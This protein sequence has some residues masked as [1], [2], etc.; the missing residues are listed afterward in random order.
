MATIKIKNGSGAPAA[1]DLVQGEPA[2][3][4]TNKRLYTEDSGGN[5]I[6]IGTNPGVDVTFADNRKAVFGT[7]SD[8]Q[9]FHDGSNSYVQDAGDG[10]LI[11]NT[12][13]GG[14]V[15][16][17]SAGETMATF[18]SN[19]AVNL[20]YD[21]AAKLATASTGIDVT[22]TVTADGLTVNSGS[23]NTVATFQSTDRTVVIPLIDSDGSTQIRSIDGE[24]AIRTGGDG[25]SSANTVERMRIDS[26]GNVGIGTSLPAFGAISTGI[27]VEGTTAGIRLQGATTGALELYHNNGLSTIDSRTATGGSKLAFNTENTERMR[28]DSSGNVLVGKTSSNYT[29]AG[30]ELR[31]H[32]TVGGTT[33][34]QTPFFANRTTDDGAL[35]EFYRGTGTV[36]SIQTFGGNLQISPAT[37]FGVDAPTDIFL[38]SAGVTTFKTNGTENARIDASGNLLVGTTET[39]IGF[40]ASGDGCMLAPEG[41]LQ[42]ARDSANELLYL[43]KLGGNDGDII[44]LSTD[45]N[46]IGVLGVRANYI[47]IG[48]GDTQLLFN[49][50]SDAI[51]PEGLTANRDAAIDLG[52]TVS[53][54]KDL[55]LSGG[56]RGT[57]TIDITIPETSG[58]AINLEFG[59]N[60][61]TTRRTVQAYK[62]NFEPATADTGV[63]SLGQ[64]GNQWKNL[65]LS[66]GVV[67]GATS[68]NVSSKTLDDYEEGTFTGAVADASSGGNESSSTLNGTYVK[69]GAVVYV[70]FNVSNINTTGMTAGNDV[71]ITG[72]PFA[73]KSVSGTAK[74]TGTANLSVVTFEQTPFMQVNEG[75]TYVKILEVRSGAG[76]D[77]VVVSQ[78]SS[79][80]SDIHGNLVYETA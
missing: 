21:N 6:E 74:Y 78:L 8:L 77:A 80:A 48:N 69:V 56:V 75:Q 11:L 61:N 20:Y 59:N 4:L 66:G 7:G 71:F 23:T 10:A 30:A 24:F 70:Q 73:S 22:G 1:S 43:N 5:V 62:D 47:K 35:F 3:D 53:R 32:G 27:E 51:T 36:G 72:L 19:G 67:F 2:L 9:L 34:T 18:N 14:W 50:G 49:S 12:T 29:I 58:G 52:R 40:T 63:I 13:N 60:T 65:Y 42:L 57:S 15:Y 41:T 26:S 31:D 37:T 64:A 45:G 39:D 55:Y 38:D 79:G 54:F 68:G 76:N 16:V 25:G 46:E 44:R 17:Y 33:T 28:I